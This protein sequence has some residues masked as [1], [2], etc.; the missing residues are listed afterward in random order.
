MSLARFGWLGLAWFVQALIIRDHFGKAGKSRYGAL[1]P[2]PDWKGSARYRQAMRV[3]AWCVQ[4]GP[5]K[6]GMERHVVLR[7]GKIRQARLVRVGR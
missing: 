5:G 3:F 1:R 6:A 2:V 7:M 4:E